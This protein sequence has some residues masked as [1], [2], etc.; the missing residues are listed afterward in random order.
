LVKEITASPTASKDV[1]NLLPYT[2]SFLQKKDIRVLLLNTF[3][4]DPLLGYTIEPSNI[5]SYCLHH[6]EGGGGWRYPFDNLCIWP[7][8][9]IRCP[10]SL[11]G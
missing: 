8:L 4:E 1:F 10:T 9:I 5:P 2:F 6:E 11:I 7:E 3:S